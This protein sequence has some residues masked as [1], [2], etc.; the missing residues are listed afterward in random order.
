MICP[1]IEKIQPN[2][3][4]KKWGS[5][6]SQVNQTMQNKALS[7]DKNLKKKYKLFLNKKTNYTDL[8]FCFEKFFISLN[9]S[10]ET[11]KFFTKEE[12]PQIIN[13]ALNFAINR[14][15]NY[16]IKSYIIY[17]LWENIS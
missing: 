7:L 1:L 11:N 13:N 3:I 4:P 17:D 8:L 5:A 2:E 15:K 6:N 9:N 16:N 10:L 12:I 14:A